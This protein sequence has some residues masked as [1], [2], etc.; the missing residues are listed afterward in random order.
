M[1]R[2][3]AA[4]LMWGAVTLGACS[5]EHLAAS[6]DGSA[7]TS[8]S[9]PLDALAVDRC[10][11]SLSDLRGRCQASFDG[12]LADLPAC[13]GI[14][15]MVRA[16]G[17]VIAIVQGSGVTAVTCYYDAATHALVGALELSDSPGFC[18]GSFGRADGQIPGPSCDTTAPFYVR[19][20]PRPDAG[21]D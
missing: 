6:R 9:A 17:D 7:D 19:T 1:T 5:P 14:S 16:C 18:G 15:Q 8:T 2:F 20:C 12:T 21:A 3:A 10:T 4:T 11:G 13:T